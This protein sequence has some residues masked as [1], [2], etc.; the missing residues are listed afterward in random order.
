[1][2]AA[3]IRVVA[4]APAEG[5]IEGVA[6]TR[7]FGFEDDVVMRMRDAHG[8]AVVVDVRSKSRVG[9]SD[10]GANAERIERVLAEL[11]ALSAE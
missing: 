1:M 8:M 9:V 7:W 2:R 6:R 3:G 4:I 11:Q 5:R 10:V